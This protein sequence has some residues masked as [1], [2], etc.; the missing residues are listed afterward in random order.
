MLV[1]FV[2]FNL[3]FVVLVNLDNVF[4]YAAFRIGYHLNA[5]ELVAHERLPHD[6]NGG[7]QVV[8]S[9]S[10]LTHDFDNFD[11]RILPE[12]LDEDRFGAPAFFW[13]LDDLA[14]ACRLLVPRREL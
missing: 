4:C 11:E 9:F 1:F 12:K 3:V 14:L 2:C 10:E 13:L 6:L 8:C 7:G 5:E